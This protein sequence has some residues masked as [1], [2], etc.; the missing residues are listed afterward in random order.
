MS[1]LSDVGFLIMKNIGVEKKEDEK[2]LRNF[3]ELINFSFCFKINEFKKIN[4]IVK[5]LNQ[6]FSPL[7]KISLG[8]IIDKPHIKV[9][10]CSI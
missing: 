1:R 7:N 2:S 5:K 9:H 8:V 6:S 3:L 10:I 4:I